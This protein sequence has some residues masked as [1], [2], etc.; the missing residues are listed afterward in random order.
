[1]IPQGIPVGIFDAIYKVRETESNPVIVPL[2]VPAPKFEARPWPVPVIAS[3]P[4]PVAMFEVALVPV[5]VPV[6][7]P[8]FEAVSGAGR[9]VGV[10]STW[11]RAPVALLPEVSVLVADSP[12]NDL[13]VADPPITE[14]SVPM[15]D[16]VPLVIDPP[17]AEVSVPEGPVPVP[18]TVGMG[19][20]SEVVNPSSTIAP[21]VFVVGTDNVRTLTEV[22]LP[23]K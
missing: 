21:P 13:S 18:T 17:V 19:V 22:G 7:V 10:P 15:I 16:P 11:N 9:G 5:P 2:P 14:V 20:P 23:L 6:P 12:N 1:M 4:V 8:V 3:M